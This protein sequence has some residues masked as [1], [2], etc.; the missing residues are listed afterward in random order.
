MHEQCISLLDGY[1]VYWMGMWQVSGVA[2]IPKLHR[3]FLSF[4]LPF[5]LTFGVHV[6]LLLQIC[7]VT[8]INGLH[9]YIQ[10]IQ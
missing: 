3:S 9:R 5:L 2:E 7:Q 4:L 6:R 10:L 8:Y 1:A